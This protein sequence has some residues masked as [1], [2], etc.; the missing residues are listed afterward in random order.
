[1]RIE[2]SPVVVSIRSLIYLR[3]C[4]VC[5]VV[6]PYPYYFRLDLL[7]ATVFMNRKQPFLLFLLPLSA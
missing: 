3:V 5:V 1:M 7:V 4:L 6:L 2:R